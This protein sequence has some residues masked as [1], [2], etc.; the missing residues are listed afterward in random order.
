MITTAPIQSSIKATQH[1]PE[2]TVHRYFARR[3]HNVINHL[4]QYYANEKNSLIFD[5]FGG[6]GTM[7]YEA[8]ICGNRAIACDT[9]DLSTFIME[10]EALM[11]GADLE[12]L[13]EFVGALMESLA[14]VFSP[15][16]T[17]R[18]REVYWI[19]WSSYTT[20]PRC[21]HTTYLSPFNT[22]GAGKYLCGNCGGEFKP[23]RVQID[24]VSPVEISLLDP[25]SIRSGKAGAQ[26]RVKAPV[27]EL[28]N[29]YDQL[30]GRLEGLGLGASMI[31]STPIP[32]CNLQR[33]SALH[34][35]GIVY[36]EQLIPRATRAVITYIGNRIQN[37]ELAPDDRRR[38]LFVLSANL[39]YCS[40]FSTLNQA[41]R[42]DRPMEWAKS[43]FW[44]PYT[45][46]EVNPVITFYERWQ[47]Y[48]AAVRNARKKFA[49]PP[50]RGSCKQ[51]L[52][53][54][55]T[56]A[57]LN[58]SS[59]AVP[60]LPDRSVDLVITDPPYGS[61]LHYG[62]LSAFWTT[63]LSKFLPEIQSVPNRESEAVP[64]R[65]KG[66]PGWKTFDEYEQIL[67]RVFS[68]AYRVLKDD[69]YCVVTFN[70]K[71]PEA[72]VAF[73]RA[74]KRAGF[75][76][77]KGGII[78][79]DGVESY[80]KSID[81]RRGGA[82]F[83]DFI[84]SFLKSGSYHTEAPSCGVTWAGFLDNTLSLLANEHDRI[85]NVDLYTKLYLDF[86]PTLFAAIDPEKPDGEF[87]QNMTFHNFEQKIKEYF[88][89]SDG[90]WFRKSELRSASASHNPD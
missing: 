74:V 6:G 48:A 7:L 21:R 43:N 31:P 28:Q 25:G 3:P 24:D 56:F 1:D 30:C 29:Y 26:T 22:S 12:V 59:E 18:N 57:V 9:S 46:V 80:K 72:W 8:L 32:D 38:L 19:E 33:E 58:T 10:Q 60:D 41:W 82:I 84:Y 36:F 52:L 70:N 13:T 23:Q 83:G 78:F 69:R 20:C 34:K 40:R 90:T 85:P 76:L 27:E 47:S 2:Y 89:Y 37:S 5:P 62:E 66:Y 4:I 54:Q 86:L 14:D 42:G 15:L 73:L 61:Y 44:T 16:Y 79:Q 71:E 77:P 45:F 67:S 35:K 17:F 63:W 11:P 81:S 39:R 75:I 49:V 87:I 55:S 64:A 65:K 53:G 68:E 50:R 51:V 88:V